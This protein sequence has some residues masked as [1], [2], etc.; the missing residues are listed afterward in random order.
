MKSLR[1]RQSTDLNLSWGCKTRSKT[2]DGLLGGSQNGHIFSGQKGDNDGKQ[3]HTT[4]AKNSDEKGALPHSFL[5]Y[6]NCC[7]SFY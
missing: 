3:G 2:Q 1:G 4:R 5:S 7:M 6:V